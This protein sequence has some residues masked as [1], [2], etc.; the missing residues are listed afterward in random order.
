MVYITKK[1]GKF[2]NLE[3]KNTLSN[4]LTT[5]KSQGSFLKSKLG[6]VINKGFNIGLRYVLPDLI[7]DQ[8]IN[9]KDTILKEGLKEGI[10]KAVDESINIG[11]SALGIVTGNF[12]NIDQVQTAIKKGGIIDSIGSGMDK[13]I[14]KVEEKGL[15]SSNI[16]R[17][18]KNGK[19]TI[20]NT[21]SNN[22]ENEFEYQL[23][24]I[25]KLNKYSKN[26]KNYFESKNFEGMEREYQKIEEKI[27][28]IIPIENTINK[29]RKIENL[30]NLI[31]NKGQKFDLSED[32]LE[33]TKII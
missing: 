5:E 32:E 13:T 2:M 14:N 6:S 25:E 30:H 11:K 17:T 19:N 12:E 22:I 20:L 10:Q 24:S 27:K 31:K 8:V 9:I 28:D 21:I 33:L 3:I 4:E 26:W 15:I 18:I 23:D 1:K 16:S 29:V 7:E